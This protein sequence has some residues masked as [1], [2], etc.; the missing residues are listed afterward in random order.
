MIEGVRITDLKLIPDDRGYLMEMLRDDDPNFTK[1]GQCYASAT[2]PGVIKA[3]H[4]HRVQTDN[5]CCVSGNVRVGL[6]DGRE[7][8]PTS[9]QSQAI[10]VGELARK[11]ITIPPGVWHGWICLGTQTAIVIN[12]PSEHYNYA[13]PDELRRPWDDPEIAFEWQRKGG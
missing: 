1:F 10:V 3:W 7:D 8:S 12:M 2:Y 4:A 9:R 11:R 6:W 5:F 13:E